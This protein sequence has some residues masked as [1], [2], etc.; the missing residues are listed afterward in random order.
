[1]RSKSVVRAFSFVCACCASFFLGRTSG[2]SEADGVPPST[3][4]CA[5]TETVPVIAS[6]KTKS[7]VESDEDAVRIAREAMIE[8]DSNNL[9]ESVVLSSG[10]YKLVSFRIW[11]NPHD[12]NPPGPDKWHSPV[13][14]DAEAGAVVPPQ[15][16]DWKPMTDSQLKMFVLEWD[17]E[18][19][20]EEAKNWN[21]DIRH[22]SG[23]ARIV[24]RD[25]A[26]P[27]GDI[28]VEDDDPVAVEYWVDETRKAMIC[29]YD[30]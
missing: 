13:W 26:P 9:A 23:F 22:V 1:M 21:W 10:Q 11:I 8:I 2:K 27:S 4:E 3:P 29:A 6:P 16:P 12:P 5:A 30:L 19:N 20:G 28:W 17:R 18:M 14:I 7:R 24:V 15:L 25:P